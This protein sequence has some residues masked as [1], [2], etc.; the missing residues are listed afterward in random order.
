[1]KKRTS[2]LALYLV[3][4]LAGC[5]SKAKPQPPNQPVNGQCG[6]I[7]GTCVQGIPSGTGDTTPPYGWMCLGINRG[8][9]DTCS[10]PTSPIKPGEIFSG[11][12]DLA[13]KVKAAGPL[14]GKMVVLDPTTGSDDPRH[15]EMMERMILEMGIPGE[16]LVFTADDPG[17]F[18]KQDKWQE[19]RVETLVISHPTTW[20][21]LF[22]YGVPSLVTELNTLH[23]AAAGNTGTFGNRD[24]W[25]PEH[26]NWEEYPGAYKNA[27]KVFATGK[28]ILAT[29]AKMDSQ[30]NVV[31]FL[32]TVRCGNAKDVCFSVLLPVDGGHTSGASVRLGALTFYLSQLWSTPQEV[33]DVLN[34]CAEDVGEPGVDE[35]FGR[36][37]PSVVCETVR[38]REVGMVVRTTTVS[39]FSPVLN[40]MTAMLVPQ[41]QSIPQPKVLDRPRFFYAINGYNL[42]TVTGHLGSQLSLKGADFFISGGADRTP[43]GIRSS[44]LR[45]TRVPFIEFGTRR[46]LFSHGKY[47]VSLFGIYGYSNGN[48]MSAHVGHLGVRYEHPFVSGILFFDT[49]YRQTQGRIGIPGYQEAGAS[50]TPFRNNTPEVRLSFSLNR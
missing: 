10:V 3:F 27:F 20:A 48:S 25:Y 46:T 50:P 37:V 45:A 29:L 42:E 44:L 14:W 28:V 39:S 23:V 36:G 16:N 15:A 21:T 49:G 7:Q 4:F 40:Q 31:P 41:T 32:E 24:L 2:V 19:T 17:T 34:V 18:F 47:A 13:Q 11:Q 5:A 1:M 9:D 6:I 22:E 12:R 43:L 35:E 38:N 30:G 33:V 8:M 26:P